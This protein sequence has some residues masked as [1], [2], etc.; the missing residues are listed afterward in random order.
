MDELAKSKVT[1]EG[2]SRKRKR[3]CHANERRAL[4]KR[5]I[6]DSPG[7]R[8]GEVYTW[9]DARMIQWFKEARK[10]NSVSLQK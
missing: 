1:D 10:T 9:L 7:V 2:D 6:G 4:K 3:E 5:I 8:R